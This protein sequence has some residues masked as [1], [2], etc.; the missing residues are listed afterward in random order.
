[1]EHFGDVVRI[2][3]MNIMNQFEEIGNG[4]VEGNVLTIRYSYFGETGN[5]VATLSADGRHLKGT[6]KGDDG[7]S[8]LITL[9][10]EHLRGQ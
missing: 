2:G 3:A 1:M 10:H 7:T 8:E 5:L 6:D 4:R 9:H